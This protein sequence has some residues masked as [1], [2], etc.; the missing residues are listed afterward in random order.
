MP[1][2]S[3]GRLPEGVAAGG[4]PAIIG[5]IAPAEELS[6][7][8]DLVAI[9]ATV[10]PSVSATGSDSITIDYKVTQ[11][12]NEPFTIGIYAGFN[13]T[14]ADFSKALLLNTLT[15]L[16]T[17][18]IPGGL[19]PGEVQIVTISLGRKVKPADGTYDV[20]L[21]IGNTNGV[22]GQSET[23]TSFAAVPVTL[24][25][26][27]GNQSPPNTA[28]NLTFGTFLQ[29]GSAPDASTLTPAVG[30]GQTVTTV[31]AVVD[32]QSLNVT[33]LGGGA[34]GFTIDGG[35]VADGAALV[36]TAT[37]SNGLAGGT[38][39]EVVHATLHSIPIPDWL[40]STGIVQAEVTWDAADQVYDVTRYESVLNAQPA[41]LPPQFPLP[42]G[43]NNFVNSG[44]YL[45][46][47]FDLNG[48]VTNQTDWT[49]RRRQP[50]RL[51]H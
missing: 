17:A 44:T 49:L 34:Y 26:A 12:V 10:D 46:F 25:A 30:S 16:A 1:P 6:Q 47:N 27:F 7:S 13:G 45:G 9:S 48:N 32:G 37:L 5:G 20:A 15:P 40:Q 35:Q 21:D 29:G 39:Q 18:D 2:F 23:I 31:T 24:T 14:A 42:L 33:N 8:A 22:K 11:D 38:S 51:L 41:N 3:T 36:V 28:D 4:A 19:T 43:N 50:P